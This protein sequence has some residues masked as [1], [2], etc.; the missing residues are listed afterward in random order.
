MVERGVREALA[1]PSLSLAATESKLESS[2]CYQG[3]VMSSESYRCYCLDGSGNLHE[4]E[5]FDADHD[6]HAIEQ[7]RTKYPDSK[8]EIWQGRR[9]VA[10]LSPDRLSA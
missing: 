10:S 4:P 7:L 1:V 6:E 5:W 9:L 8:C 3:S 2:R